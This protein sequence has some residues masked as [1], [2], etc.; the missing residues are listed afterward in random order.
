MAVLR[1][2][3]DMMPRIEAQEQID[4]VEAHSLAYGAYGV[5][6]GRRLMRTLQSIANGGK[7]TTNK[8][9]SAS[10]MKLAAAGIGIVMAEPKE[11]AGGNS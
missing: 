9:K 5:K 1:A 10:K 7:S 11:N 4:R 2:M 8:P 6:Q 3:L